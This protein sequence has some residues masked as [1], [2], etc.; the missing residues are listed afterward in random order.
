MALSAADRYH[1]SFTESLL[2]LAVEKRMGIVG[3]K[4]PGRGRLLASWTPPPVE[5]QRN[6]WE[7]A[8]IATSP[9]PLQMHEAMY[10][11]LSLPVTRS[12]WAAIPSRNWK[13][14]CNLRANSRH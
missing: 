1:F 8:V 14:T 2:P 4:V 10:Y 11:A 6:S 9:G 13:K 3:M 12:S 5:R 7:G